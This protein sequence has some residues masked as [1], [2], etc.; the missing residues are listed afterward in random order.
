V[1]ICKDASDWSLLNEHVLL[2]SRKHGQLRQAITKMVQ[3]VMSF[4]DDAPS[5]DV[6]LSVIETLRTVTEGKVC[7]YISTSFLSRGCGKGATGS[8]G[9][10][11]EERERTEEG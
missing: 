10:E 5:L 2:L 8:S 1:T 6:K 11:G 3:V 9:G 7:T 4:L